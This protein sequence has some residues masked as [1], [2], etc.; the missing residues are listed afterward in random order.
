MNNIKEYFHNATLKLRTI[1]DDVI[2]SCHLNLKPG[3]YTA[4][5]IH[6]ELKRRDKDYF[7]KN[8]TSA[9]KASAQEGSHGLYSFREIS[10]E[11]GYLKFPSGNVFRLL[12]EFEKEGGM[13]GRKAYHFTIQEKRTAV[14]E[15]TITLPSQKTMM[16]LSKMVRGQNVYG[17]KDSVLSLSDGCL[18]GRFT[19]YK[20]D[21]SGNRKVVKKDPYRICPLEFDG[22]AEFDN[23]SFRIDADSI[24][25]LHGRCKLAI[26]IDES[27]KWERI[28]PYNI[29]IVI[30]NEDG[31][32]ISSD[33]LVDFTAEAFDEQFEFEPIIRAIE[34]LS[35]P[36]D[37]KNKKIRR[38]DSLP[39]FL[40]KQRK[41]PKRQIKDPQSRRQHEYIEHRVKKLHFSR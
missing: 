11:T 6:N 20:Y 3:T 24:K 8:I 29:R 19:S 23:L 7:V 33:A 14:A 10:D 12:K 39:V 30:T 21:Y 22:M 2:D 18:R 41:I 31:W 37:E 26:Y 5:Q 16:K 27:P 17:H 38:P 1:A 9:Q 4:G 15:I 40:Q 35:S 13:S 36:N 28:N 32:M 34:E 25:H